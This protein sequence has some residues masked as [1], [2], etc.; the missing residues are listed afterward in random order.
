MPEHDGYWFLRE[1]R[2]L[3]ADKGRAI[4]VLAV[5]A[6]G[7][8]HGPDRTLPAGFNGHVRKPIDPW[9]MVRVLAGLLRRS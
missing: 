6:H 3:P 7:S 4:P 8:L 5:T 9:E 1:L 2:A